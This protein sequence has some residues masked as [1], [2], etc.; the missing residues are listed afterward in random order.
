MCYV[1]LADVPCTHSVRDPNWDGLFDVKNVFKS[2]RWFTRGWTLQEL[3]A[4]VVVEFYA[5][6]WSFIGTKSNLRQELA[7]I[8]GIDLEVLGGA[9]LSTCN[10][11]ERMSW[12]AFRETTRVEDQA[13][14]LLGIFQIN[15]PLLYGEGKRA[16]LRLQE[17]ILKR[18]DDYTVLTWSAGLAITK[19]LD[20]GLEAGLHDIASAL[21]DDTSGFR[22]ADEALFRYSDMVPVPRHE[23]MRGN[24]SSSLSSD[25]LVLDDSP[26]LL[27][28][29]GLRICLPLST[30]STDTYLACIYCKLRSTKEL[31]CI[32]LWRTQHNS[33][34]F[35]R[36]LSGFHG[37]HLVSEKKLPHFTRYTIYIDQQNPGAKEKPNFRAASALID[38]ANSAYR[39]GSDLLKHERYDEAEKLFT[40]ALELRDRALG[41]GH[42]ATLKCICCLSTIYK[43]QGRYGEAEKL[44]TQLVN[45]RKRELGGENAVTLASMAELASTISRQGRCEEAET[46]FLTVIDESKRVLGS[47]HPDTITSMAKLASHSWDHNQ[48]EAKERFTQAFKLFKA[49]LGDEYPSIPNVIGNLVWKQ[50][51]INRWATA[52]ELLVEF[53]ELSKKVLGIE[54]PE[55]L[56]AVSS[57]A[58]IYERNSSWKKA[59]ELEEQVFEIRKRILGAEHPDTLTS[60]ANLAQC[61][62]NQDKKMDEEVD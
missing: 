47:Q 26:P 57:L 39:N 18:Y 38:R 30:L 53:T 25:V 1:Y 61:R 52:E 42:S 54:H 5:Q 44:N 14:S 13:Y 15:M 19:S 21:V 49:F 55:T 12:A 20:N 50:R 8:T 60:I 3:I 7:L 27:T 34:I 31:V 41:A 24:S 43:R 2:S 23:F 58:S 4:P 37:L 62:T 28:G 59:E 9:E 33:D 48:L 16:F 6:D 40:Q 56:L 46:M 51:N 22:V 35:R 32:A 10:V 29:R 45:M 11:A 17:E 36:D